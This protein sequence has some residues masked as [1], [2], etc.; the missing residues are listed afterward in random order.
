[1]SSI[2]IFS[3]FLA[4]T[5][6]GLILYVGVILYNLFFSK[7]GKN[8]NNREFYECGF[9]NSNDSIVDLDIHFSLI[10]ILFLIYEMELIIF[11]PMFLNMFG[12]N[13]FNVF[14][15]IIS[16]II[17]FFSYLYEWDRYALNLTF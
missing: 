10:G 8:I 13:Y 11:V 2:S 9:K 16:L 15:L 14:L 7:S 17:L 12:N 3:S 1:M 4:I 5:I 6:F